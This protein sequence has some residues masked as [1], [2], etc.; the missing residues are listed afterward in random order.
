M[1]SENINMPFADYDNNDSLL[2]KEVIEELSVSTV[3]KTLHHGEKL[4]KATNKKA[5]KF[6][7]VPLID[8]HT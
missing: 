4:I 1:I 5:N 3:H 7:D 8:L 6:R 2:L